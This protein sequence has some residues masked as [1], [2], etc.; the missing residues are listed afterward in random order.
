MSLEP[1]VRAERLMAEG[2]SRLA[3]GDAAAANELYGEAA[4]LEEE[5]FFS[6]PEDLRKTRGAVAVSVAALYRKAGLLDQAAR[7]A[8]QFLSQPGLPDFARK[9]L[10][11]IALEAENRRL[12]GA[13]GATIGTDSFVVSL[14]GNAILPGGL[15]PLDTVA[16]K[17]EQFRNLVV[18]IGE[19]VDNRP[20]RDKG[21]PPDELLR[22]VTP[23][24]S[25]A[26]VGSHRFELRLQANLQLPLF[27][28]SAANRIGR[29][30]FSILEIAS[31]EGELE[32]IA[33]PN[34]RSTFLR[35]V[36]NLAP[37]GRDLAEIEVS[38]TRTADSAVLRP[39]VRRAIETR[40]RRERRARRA[41]LP[42][43]TE[44]YGVL[45]ALHL[46]EGWIVLV[47]NGEEQKCWIGDE[48]VIDDV[49]GPL[50]NH[51]V[52]VVGHWR[53]LRHFVVEDIIEHVPESAG[54]ATDRAGDTSD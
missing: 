26:G 15:A 3:S 36:R 41:E 2:D 31:T 11:D 9:S 17:Y 23:L 13:A 22:L 49:V 39:Q 47:E 25:P 52:E 16:Q 42:A 30:F 50:V 51:H 35:M 14:R 20:F 33:D 32:I 21:G 7:A 48:K 24:V 8:H 19:W 29:E 46:D 18:R 10:L 28:E 37:S 43:E 38:R 53:D 6:T 5:V 34:Y 12:V 27:A 1:H 44:R 45:R 54:P 4:R 40:I